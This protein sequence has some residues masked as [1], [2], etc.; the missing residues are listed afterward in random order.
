MFHKLIELPTASLAIARVGTATRDAARPAC[1][2][3]IEE[4]SRGKPG[5]YPIVNRSHSGARIAVGVSSCAQIGVDVEVAR[6][7]ACFAEAADWRLEGDIY[8]SLVLKHP[9]D[10]EAIRCA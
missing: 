6:P 10:C 4:I 8:Y 5:H 3:L 7:R 1:V 2:Q 9:L